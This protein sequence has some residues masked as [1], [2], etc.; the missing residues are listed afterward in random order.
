MQSA[1]ALQIGFWSLVDEVLRDAG[2]TTMSELRDEE[3]EDRLYRGERD[4]QMEKMEKIAS[5]IAEN[6]LTV[7]GNIEL[8]DYFGYAG[9]SPCL[10]SPLL[11]FP[12][13][14]SPPLLQVT[15]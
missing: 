4:I 8:R 2:D 3:K 15:Q 11:F 13:L 14:L 5:R 12:L 9:I 10:F 6:L 1:M 7:S